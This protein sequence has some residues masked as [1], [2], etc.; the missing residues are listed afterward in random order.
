MA[1][2]STMAQ[3]LG[4]VGA[5]TRSPAPPARG[6][7]VRPRLDAIDL[8]RGVVIVLMALDHARD[9]LCSETVDPTNLAK[10]SAALFLTRW[11]T[12]YCAP[13]FIFLA[14]TGAYLSGTRGK[15]TGE[16]SWFLFSRGLWLVLLDLTYVRCLGWAF[17]FEMLSQGPGTLWAIGW[18][19]VVLAALVWLPASAVVTFGVLL[20]ALHN[21]FDTVRAVD[22]GPFGWIWTLLH[23]GE[24]VNWTWPAGG[25]LPT[26]HILSNEE[27]AS[28]V[29][30][31]G[32]VI[33]TGY[34]LIPWAG[35]MAAGYGLGALF[36]L[37]SAARRSQ[38]WGLGLSLTLAFVALRA[39]GF[40]FDPMPW[41]M[42]EPWWKS[43]LS[44]VNCNKYPPSLLY[45][46]MTLGPAIAALA[47][48]DRAPGLLGKFFI[49]FGRVPLFFYLLHLPLLH[50]LGVGLSYWRHGLVP[51]S[52]FDFPGH[53]PEGEGFP[54]PLIYLFW[55]GAVLLLFP[56]CW[57]FGN[58]KR[59]HKGA[60]LSY[61]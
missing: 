36:R 33:G 16:L 48:F 7:T 57:W 6:D 37:D 9:F 44:F 61:L 51:K 49:V 38:L 24:P 41:S 53:A 32:L 23:S 52:W 30:F 40:Y 42:R 19:M 50:G 20:I 4:R 31:T 25:W 18:S 28:G 35:V 3:D 13:V 2:E 1:R 39:T 60:W 59:R 27:R 17:N 34:G 14:G 15:T 21:Q 58:F 10:A 46:L 43:I 22:V 45:L 12:H 29:Q 8:L 47:A 5:I 55:A 26:W 11:I 56:L 54:L